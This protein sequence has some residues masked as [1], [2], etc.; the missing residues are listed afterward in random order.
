MIT[1]RVVYCFVA[2][3]YVLLPDYLIC[4][5][6][7]FYRKWCYLHGPLHAFTSLGF[8]LVVLLLLCVKSMY[9]VTLLVGP[10]L[11]LL[12]LNSGG[13]LLTGYA[14]VAVGSHISNLLT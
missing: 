4:I 7:H 6:V 8:F 2:R 5:P 11:N 10:L 1:E 13:L 3:K 12:N 9:L 14:T